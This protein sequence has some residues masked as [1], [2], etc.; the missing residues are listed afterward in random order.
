MKALE[1]SEPWLQENPIKI[2]CYQ[3]GK[4]YEISRDHPLVQTAAAILPE[5]KTHHGLPGRE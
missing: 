3:E 4:P 5:G 2:E 1:A